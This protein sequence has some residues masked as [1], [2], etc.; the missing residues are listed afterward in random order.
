MK[1]S[2]QLCHQEAFEKLIGLMVS[3][4]VMRSPDQ[5]NPFVLDT[6]A[7]LAIGTELSQ[8]VT[9]N[10]YAVAY[11]SASQIY[12]ITQNMCANS[13]IIYWNHFSTHGSS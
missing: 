9:G 7:E 5:D 1:F 2:W 10:E 11:G 6:D 3:A 13:G 4:L 8:V 12:C